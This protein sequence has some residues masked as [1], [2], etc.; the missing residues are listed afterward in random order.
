MIKTKYKKNF[1]CSL[2][3]K[4]FLFL[5]KLNKKSIANVSN[6][7]VFNVKKNCE[8]FKVKKEIIKENRELLK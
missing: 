5:K 8:I 1:F 2:M 3:F 4:Y 7:E 6:N